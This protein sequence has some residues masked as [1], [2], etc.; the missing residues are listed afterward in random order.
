MTLPLTPLPTAE[1]RLVGLFDS[2]LGGLSVLSAVHHTL[3][4][5]PLLY[6]ADSRHAPYGER[7]DDFITAR[8]LA[9]GRHLV[10]AGAQGVVVACNTATAVAVAALRAAWPGLP[11]VGVEP[12]IKPAVASSTSGRIG[13]MATPGT[14][15]SEKFKRLLDAHRGHATVVLQP[16]P[17][18]AGLIEQGHL[19]APEMV[20]LIDGFCAPL[21]EAAVDT[22]VLGCTHYPFVR[23]HIQA[24]MGPAVTLLDTAL[25]VARQTARLL[26]SNPS[27]DA[28]RGLVRLQTTG[29]TAH[30]RQVASRWLD[31]PCDVAP[32]PLD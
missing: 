16:C 14:L 13:V 12:A 6:V 5:T 25:P 31:F 3:P 4:D 15:R 18:L 1:R 26:G 29:D 22:V 11:V 30:L 32:T 20:T 27:P 2:G 10:D 9:V 23:H 19:D 24:A 21:R 17:G 28:P 8:T 7:S